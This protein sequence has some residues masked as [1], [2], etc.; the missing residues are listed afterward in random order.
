MSRIPKPDPFVGFTPEQK[1]AFLRAG[2]KRP[3]DLDRAGVACAGMFAKA[4]CPEDQARNYFMAGIWL[5]PKQI[6][7]AALCRQCDRDG[8]PKY[9]GF[10]GPRGPGKTFAL[11]AQSGADDCQRYPG[12]KVLFLRKVGR[13]G[14]EQFEDVRIKVFPQLKHNYRQGK[15]LTFENG[16]RIILG[17]FKDEK[18]IDNYLGQEYDAMVIEELTTFSKDKWDNILSCLRT[19]KPGWRPRVYASWNWGG[20]GHCIPFGEVLTEYRGWIDISKLKVGDH[21]YTVTPE[22]KMVPSY[23]SQVHAER[24]TGTLKTVRQRGFFMSCTPKHSVARMLDLSHGNGNKFAL[25]PFNELPGHV[26]LL[27]SVSWEGCEKENFDLRDEG[28]AFIGLDYRAKQLQPDSL[29]GDD[30]LELVGWYASEGY[31]MYKKGNSMFG[32]CQSKQAMRP[33]IKRLLDRCGFNYTES[34]TG[35]SIYS[36]RWALYFMQFGKCREKHLPTESK[37]VSARQL[38]ILFNALINGDGHWTSVEGGSGAYYTISDRLADEVQE[39]AIKLGY[40][41][42]IHRR[43][44]PNRFGKEI[45]VSFKTTNGGCSEILTGQHQNKVSTTTKRKSCVLDEFHDGMVFC[46]GVPKTHTFL[47]RQNG[48]VWISGNSWVKRLFWD[49][50]V[51]G[52]EVNTRL[53]RATVYDNKHVD[54]EYLKYLEALSGWK[55]KSWLEGDPNFQAGQFFT[56]WSDET[57]VLKAYDER[58]IVRWYGGMDY[59]WTHPNVFL[60]AG[61]DR[62]GDLIFL[63]EHSASQMTVEEHATFIHAMLG[64]RNM[65]PNDLDFI[66]AGRDCFSK[67]EDGTTIADSYSAEGIE[68]VPAEIDRVN[69]WAKMLARMGDPAKGIRPTLYVHERCKELITQIPLAQ[70]SE[71]RPEDI[72][73]MNASPEDDSGGDDALECARNVCATNPSGALRFCKP[74][75]LTDFGRGALLIER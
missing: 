20:I 41:T 48:S 28:D 70:H 17:H 45:R 5:Q 7:F 50:S 44:R 63:E 11:L 14:K 54:K 26:K 9:I 6:E 55:R 46:I 29:N 64:R 37:N 53:L 66:A 65:K 2:I 24:F 43:Q 39:I 47:V 23:V 30:W 73:K 58:K 15:D 13:A 34:K 38:R 35:F 75:A 40:I 19:S 10:G 18:E 1:A 59:G 62:D 67:K 72:E 8:G 71:R 3:T 4:G 69:G 25:T 16:S 52:R 22:G 33:K 68:L 56:T 74:V 27:R 31:A 51:E 57:H 12:L 42:H 21:I 32:I 60:L 49:A 36:R 61:E